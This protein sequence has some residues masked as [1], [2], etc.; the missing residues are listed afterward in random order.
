MGVAQGQDLEIFFWNVQD[1]GIRDGMGV[2]KNYHSL[3]SNFIF[4]GFVMFIL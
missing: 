1:K 2:Q 4:D 3:I